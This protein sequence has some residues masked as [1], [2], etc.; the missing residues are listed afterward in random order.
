M[1]ALLKFA[2]ATCRFIAVTFCFLAL[3]LVP[4]SACALGPSVPPEAMH[5]FALAERAFDENRL[6]EA[7]V[8][9]EKALVIYPSGLGIRVT[10]GLCREQMGK[11]ALAWE[12]MR[13]TAK[14]A[15][16]QEAEAVI[17]HDL[18]AQKHA[19]DLRVQAETAMQRIETKVGWAD[20]EFS[21]RVANVANCEVLRDGVRVLATEPVPADV[22]MH[23]F[24]A[25]DAGKPFWTTTVEVPRPGFHMRLLVDVPPPR[26][27]SIDGR[28]VGFVLMG[29]SAVPVIA[30]L[31]AVGV[32]Y[33]TRDGL[34]QQGRC[35]YNLEHCEHSDHVND[36][37]SKANQEQGIGGALLGVGAVL[38]GTGVI[39][40]I[41]MPPSDAPRPIEAFIGPSSIGLRGRF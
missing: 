11:Q 14:E 12:T 27:G 31:V 37:W 9:Y 19:R 41:T 29:V 16:S 10:L 36:V 20:I 2:M 5:F 22:G 13:T 33:G 23:I 39:L 40:A 28:K 30:G 34:V 38:L 15:K 26:P 18:R 17:K 3:S 1:I 24:T 7:E 32:G 4:D 35:D 25:R 6:G 21:E 8:L